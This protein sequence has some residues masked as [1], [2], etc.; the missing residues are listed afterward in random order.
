[1][2][3]EELQALEQVGVDELGVDGLSAFPYAEV[4]HVEDVESLVVV[5]VVDIEVY[6]TG[7]RVVG[8]EDRGPVLDES[9]EPVLRRHPEGLLEDVELGEELGIGVVDLDGLPVVVGCE[10]LVV[11]ILVGR[12]SEIAVNHSV[13]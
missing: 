12:E 11:Q 8:L 1:M 3:C 10:S 5:A 6:Q 13:V 4:A 9:R 2:P 7:G